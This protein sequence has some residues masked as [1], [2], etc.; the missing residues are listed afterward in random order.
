MRR[1]ESAWKDERGDAGRLSD[2]IKLEIRI[3]GQALGAHRINY[4]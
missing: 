4:H 1:V 2:D 3:D